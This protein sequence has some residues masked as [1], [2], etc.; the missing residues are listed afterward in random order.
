LVVAL[1]VAITSMVYSSLKSP[2]YES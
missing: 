1:T 2:Y